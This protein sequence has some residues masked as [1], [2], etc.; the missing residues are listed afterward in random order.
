MNIHL[1]FI[2]FVT[3]CGTWIVLFWKKCL[4]V[5]PCL[6]WCHSTCTTC[7]YLPMKHINWFLICF[8]SFSLCIVIPSNLSQAKHIL[9][10]DQWYILTFN[11]KLYTLIQFFF[12]DNKINILLSYIWYHFETHELLTK[13]NNKWCSLF[14]GIVGNDLKRT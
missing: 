14:C 13:Q 11:I 12:E 5:S 3:I 9:L 2:V 8:D 4:R 6:V 10:L 1:R 7:T